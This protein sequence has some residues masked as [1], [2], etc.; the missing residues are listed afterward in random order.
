MTLTCAELFSLTGASEW[1][2]CCKPLLEVLFAV[3]YTLSKFDEF[4][5]GEI[6]GKRKY[7]RDLSKGNQK[8][9]GIDL[10]YKK[11]YELIVSRDERDTK[12]KHAPLVQTRNSIEIDTS[13]MTIQEALKKMI[14]YI[15]EEA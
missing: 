14:F 7:L 11:A 8:K 15:K 9:V 10:S 5:N 13:D 2:F 3:I 12:R 6:I 1:W 4:F